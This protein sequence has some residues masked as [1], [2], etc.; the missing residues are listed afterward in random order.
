MA[1]IIDKSAG[2]DFNF[3]AIFVDAEIG[4]TYAYSHQLAAEVTE[5]MKAYRQVT[6]QLKRRNKQLEISGVITTGKGDTP[7]LQDLLS[8]VGVNVPPAIIT[9]WNVRTY[10]QVE[11]W[12]AMMHLAA[13]DN[14]VT[15]PPMPKVIERFTGLD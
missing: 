10:T 3:V 11:K 14:N 5:A 6:R 4:H 2:D 9:K 13:S 8:L 1:W 15:P 12:A 7:A